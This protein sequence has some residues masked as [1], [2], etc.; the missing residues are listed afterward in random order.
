MAG[1]VG[2]VVD[3]GADASTGAISCELMLDVW[4]GQNEAG[5]WFFLGGYRWPILIKIYLFSAR[6]RWAEDDLH[7]K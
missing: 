2:A 4:E 3:R 6:Y 7:E 5:I 1:A